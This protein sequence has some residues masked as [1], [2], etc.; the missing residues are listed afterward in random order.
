MSPDHREA[1]RVARRRRAVRRRSTLALVV[2]AVVAGL[3][4]AGTGIGG[5]ARPQPA[6]TGASSADARGQALDRGTAA[7]PRPVIRFSVGKGARG[8]AVV[9]RAGATGRR[10]VVIFLHGWGITAP[11]AYR[12][13]IRHLAA[14]GNT[15]I[16]PRYQRTARDRP[17]RVRANAVAG[18][19]R[20]LSRTSAAPDSLVVAGHSAGAALAA[21]YAAFAVRLG[22]P[23]AQAVFAVYPGR[24][25]DVPPGEI[26]EADPARIPSATRLVALAGARDAVVGEAP[27]RELVARSTQLPARRRR[28]VRVTDPSL[29]GH[30]AP[31]SSSRAARRTFWRR[32]DRLI[33]QA[34]RQ[35]ASRATQRAVDG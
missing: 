24:R 14:V 2:V 34:R 9:R 13:W 11:S 32:L 22:L 26:P 30:F 1:G 4:I 15:V 20:A 25:I 17:D 16:V 10:P 29:A 6:T 27:A 3:T 21:D 28:F 31:L 19:R 12:P 7:T 8:A 5:R 33:A 23:R 35:P 18:I